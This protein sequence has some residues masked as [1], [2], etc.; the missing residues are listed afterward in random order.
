MNDSRP[1]RPGSTPYRIFL[2]YSSDDRILVEEIV[3][4]M[5]ANGLEP[6]WAEDFSYGQGFHQQIQNFIAHSHVFLP[7]LTR[8]ADQRKWVHQEI[9]YAMALNIPVLP[10]A[11]GSLPGEMI[12][13][14]HAISVSAED[15]QLL[16]KKL[17]AETVQTLLDGHATRNVALYTC[18]EYPQERASMIASH[19]EDVLGM[20][21]F[22]HV[23]QRGGLSSFHLPSE[24]IQHRKWKERVD[25]G[26]G[27]NDEHAMAQRAER[28]S[29]TK[30][31][32]AAG[33]R[34]I[35]IPPSLAYTSFGSPARVS[36]LRCLRDFLSGMSDDDCQVAT[37]AAIDPNDNLLIVGDWFAAES[38]SMR[39]EYRQTIFTRHAPTVADKI[40][41]FDT[42]F[43]ELLEDAGV[44]AADSRRRCLDLIDEEIRA[45]EGKP[46]LKPPGEAK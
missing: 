18:A 42:E 33:C 29:L 3:R 36:R 17:T 1:C 28:L 26:T 43:Y 46:A 25:A 23:R 2:S 15:V 45:I 5:R 30:H 41:G 37:S 8:L 40:T 20:K 32:E 35:V 12:D 24:T 39:R 6:M 44:N 11:V 27:R 13:Q 16:S 10:V 19:C 22:G 34:L 31:A 4:M 21:R 7:V 38:V 14:I 9:G